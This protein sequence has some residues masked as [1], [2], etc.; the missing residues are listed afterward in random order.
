MG[1]APHKV[2]EPKDGPPTPPP[3]GRNAQVQLHGER[4]SNATHRST[5]DPEARLARK[6]YASAAKL[7][8]AGHLLMEH[9]NALIV[10]VELAKATR[11]GGGPRSAAT[12]PQAHAAAHARR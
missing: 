9:R 4:R 3:P 2:F 6:P 12:A 7:C 5:T 11:A 10:D 8:Y 1:V